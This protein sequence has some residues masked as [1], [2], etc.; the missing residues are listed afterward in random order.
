MTDQQFDQRVGAASLCLVGLVSDAAEQ[1][2]TARNVL[3]SVGY[4]DLVEA[5]ERALEVIET[6]HGMHSAMDCERHKKAWEIYCS[7]APEMRPIMLAL[8]RA[9][10]SPPLPL[11]ARQ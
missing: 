3:V 6:W 4:R 9:R 2:Q 1:I 10:S 8:M 7:R 5:L 11:N